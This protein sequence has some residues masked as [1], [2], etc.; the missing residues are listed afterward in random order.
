MVTTVNDA[1]LD[2]R[3]EL[4]R[5]NVSGSD[6]EARELVCKALGL[7]ESSFYSKRR[8]FLFDDGIDRINGLVRVRLSGVPIQH[9]IGKWEFYGLE[10]RVTEDTLIPRPD[11]E[12][13][14]DAALAF[15]NGRKKARVLDLC[16]G[17]GCVG[18]SITRYARNPITCTLADISSKALKVAKENIALNRVTGSVSAAE[19]DAREECPTAFGTF[20]LITCN[21]P[22]IPSAD[23]DGLDPEVKREPRL[24][25]DGGQ[26]GLDLY[27]AICVNFRH[28]I[29]E[30]GVIMFEVGIDQHEQVKEIMLK[31]GFEDIAVFKDLSGIERVVC[32]MVPYEITEEF[33]EENRT[34][35]AENLLV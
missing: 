13:L 5:A 2:A 19:C 31:N 22:Y 7:D 27:R 3:R 11:T 1:Y 10:F 32:G 34:N 9:I 23:I 18:I 8:E 25:L 6:I 4:R 24:A 20:D 29:K 28:A 26:D 17:T 12:T 30:G 35:V 15:V 33:E 21:P 16:C 14:V